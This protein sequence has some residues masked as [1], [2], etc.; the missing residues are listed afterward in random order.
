M[1]LIELRFEC[2]VINRKCSMANWNFVCFFLCEKENSRKTTKSLHQLV[3]LTFFPVWN[4]IQIS[5]LCHFIFVTAF[6]SFCALSVF[7]LHRFFWMSDLLLQSKRESESTIILI[8]PPSNFLEVHSC[9]ALILHAQSEN[10]NNNVKKYQAN[11][12]H[13]W[14]EIA[15][16]HTHS[17]KAKLQLNR[18]AS[19]ASSSTH[20]SKRLKQMRQF[21]KPRF[22]V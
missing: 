21:S 1:I 7:L 12:L 15:K 11:D 19:R 13:S 4:Q 17:H 9:S 8:S 20:N 18:I 2:D 6:S 5:F 3:S 16:N 14:N 10:N 22:R